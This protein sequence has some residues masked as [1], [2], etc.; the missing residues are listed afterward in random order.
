MLRNVWCWN[1]MLTSGSVGW[2]KTLHLGQWRLTATYFTRQPLQTE[3]PVI[4]HNKNTVMMWDMLTVILAGTAG[5]PLFLAIVSQC[6]CLSVYVC[7]HNFGCYKLPD[8]RPTPGAA[9]L[10]EVYGQTA[11][12]HFMQLLLICLLITIYTRCEDISQTWDLA[13]PAKKTTEWVSV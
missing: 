12:V 7:P 11:G 6:I 4:T 10:Q 9:Y 3:R 13:V 8:N 2:I 1:L 5:Q